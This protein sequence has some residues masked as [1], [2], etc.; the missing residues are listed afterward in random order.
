MTGFK[1]CIYVYIYIYY[2]RLGHLDFID[3]NESILFLVNPFRAKSDIYERQI[4][5][6]KDPGRGNRKKDPFIKI[7]KIRMA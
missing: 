4:V 6:Y 5:T 2:Q 7:D 1:F 3:F